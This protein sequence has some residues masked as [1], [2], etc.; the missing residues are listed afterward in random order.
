MNR[1]N[2][3]G[4]ITNYQKGFL[5]GYSK[6]FYYGFKNVYSDIIKAMHSNGL[7]T[8][9]IS[10]YTGMD[11]EEITKIIET[12]DDGPVRIIYDGEDEPEGFE[13]WHFGEEQGE[14]E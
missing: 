11:A 6:G 2:E 12:S 3:E 9:D 1:K 5:E 14:E 10:K 7:P 13:K 4:K 8:E